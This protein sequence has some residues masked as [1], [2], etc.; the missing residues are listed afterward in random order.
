MYSIA[1]GRYFDFA[2]MRSFCAVHGLATVPVVEH[3]F[4]LPAE[5][6]DLIAMADGKS[7]LNPE[8]D[9]EGLVFRPLRETY[10]E[11]RGSRSRLSFKAISNTYLLKEK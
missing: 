10:E 5:A 11:M 8:C 1:E 9:R 2:E 4:T 6:S 7:I 3:E